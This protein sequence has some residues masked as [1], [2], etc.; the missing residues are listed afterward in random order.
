M[1]VLRLSAL[2]AAFVL[3]LAGCAGSNGSSSLPP[4]PPPADF[5]LSVS[6]TSVSVIQGATSAPI[7][8][9]V[10]AANGFT[11]TVSVTAAGLPA[12]V[13]TSPAFPV[14]VSAGS[15]QPFT[16]T[17][18]ANT[19]AGDSTITLH[20]TSGS[21]AHDAPAMTLH[22]A[23]VQTSQVGSILY[24][25]TILNGHTARIGLETKWGGSIVEI[26]MDGANV[27]NAHDTGR[28][29]QPALYDLNG[30]LG[31]NG[32]DPV[33]GGDK[34]DHGSTVLSQQVT[35]NSLYTKT[36]PLYWNPD[37]FGGGPSAPVQSDTTFEQTVT[38][39]PDAPLAFKLHLK[40]THNGTDYHYV[41]QQEFPAVY[42]NSAYTTFVYYGDKVPWTNGSITTAPVTTT[43]SWVYTPE[44]WAALVD[45][46]N[47][48]LTVFVAGSYHSWVSVYFPGS[49]GSG[50]TGDATAYMR[51]LTEFSVGPGAVIEGDVYL[52]PGDANAARA[53]VYNLHQSATAAN[54][55]EPFGAM[56]A[57]VPNSTVSGTSFA[58]SGWALGNA[59]VSAV[60]LYVDGMLT[61][62]AQLGM[63]RPDVVAAY[64]AIAQVN[65]GWQYSLNTATLTNG[66]H[67]IAVHIVDSSNN[68]VLLLPVSVT[69]SN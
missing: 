5:T 28:E 1:N 23:A 3:A 61:G 36:S 52:I 8:V 41:T 24:L 33:L 11:G 20:G 43:T 14:G 15:P 9:S 48:G 16:V 27:V 2:V 57:P 22:T 4:P 40:L 63:A 37:A 58:V 67:T 55:A 32:W 26:S 69:V 68:E 18:P 51:S 65:C 66:M 17:V 35:S 6:P 59:P 25:Q 30:G 62:A 21:L 49:G 29:V 42:V 46:N 64:P 56:D 13:T 31:A 7:T 44:Q 47:Q 34:Y 53:V 39:V 50:P 10:V 19:A 60:K 54:L 38:A 12:G 45:V